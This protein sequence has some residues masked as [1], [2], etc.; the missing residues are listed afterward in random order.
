MFKAILT[1]VSLMILSLNGNSALLT[2]APIDFTGTVLSPNSVFTAYNYGSYPD[3]NG[4]V[5]YSS[6]D[7]YAAIDNGVGGYLLQYHL[8][9]QSTIQSIL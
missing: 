9:E 5:N 3:S 6:M 2:G 7:A 1:L 8:T 4:N